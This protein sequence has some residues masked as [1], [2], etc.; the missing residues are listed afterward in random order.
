MTSVPER[1]SPPEQTFDVRGRTY[2]RTGLD[3]RAAEWRS[4]PY[5]LRVL[6]EG[7]VRCSRRRGGSPEAVNA[8]LQRRTGAPI[9][10]FP[11]RLL[12]QD[13]LGVPLLADL[14][15]L[16]DAVADAGGDPATVD[17]R[18]PVDLVIDHSLRVDAWAGAG[19]RA[20]NLRLEHE[21]NGERF[22]FLRWCERAFANLRVVPPG[23]GIM[24]QIN[25]ERLARV[26]WTED[27][28]KAPPLAYPD[29]LLGT[30][31]HTPMVNGIG[32][33]GWGVGGIEAEA[34]ML[35][36]PVTFAIPRVIGVELR[37]RLP[38]TSTPTDLALAVTE[39]LRRV[40]VAG[41]FVE[42]FGPGL[43]ALGA[44][45]RSTIANMAP[46]QGAT[47]S[48]FPVDR[49]TVEFLHATGRR[50]DQ[51][52]LV[53]AYAHEM[54]LWWEP[55][56]A[57]PDYDHVVP[58]DL[59]G[60]RPSIAGPRR[61]EDRIDLGEAAAAF[62]RHLA[63]ETGRGAP[64]S[65]SMN[66]VHE[67]RDGA[68]VIAAI[69]S[70]TNTSHPRGMA[71]AGLV[72]RNAARRGLRPKQWVKTS[73][74][75]G[76]RVVASM[77]ERSGLQ[78]DLDA[79]GFH[80]AGFGCATCNGM[81][82]PLDPSVSAAVAEGDLVAVAVVSSNRNFAGRIHPDVRAAYLASPALV[83]AYALAGSIAV[84]LTRQPLGVDPDGGPVHLRDLWPAP[85]EVDA[86][87]GEALLPAMFDADYADLFEGGERWRAL[88][89]PPQARFP[90]DPAS[91]YI[92]RPP[93]FDGLPVDPSPRRDIVGARPLVILGDSVTTD[94]ISPSGA[95]LAN[96]AAG[97]YLRER[98][99]AAADF[100]SYGTRR[101]NHEVMVR[102]TF[103]N[104]RLRNAIVPGTEGSVTRVFPEG[105]EATVF[106]AAQE[107]AR[108]GVP[109]VV[110]AG[111]DYGCGSSRDT[112][113]KG[114]A[115][116]GVRAV[117][118]RSFERIHRSNLV[119]TGILPLEL[120][121]GV[122]AGS[123]RLDGSETFD[124]R[125][126]AG[127]VAPGAAVECTVRR[128]DGASTKVLLRCRV[129]TDEEADR[130]RHGGILPAVW[131]EFAGSA[132]TAAEASCPSV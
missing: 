58:F 128:A 53:E 85:E 80:V 11:A 19:A 119:G 116:L 51:V 79:L 123:L 81:S 7:A 29:T 66:D 2:R 27:D 21:R 112:A 76:S 65:A 56:A 70:C 99:V 101:G 100:N 59:G 55:G 8:V 26:V 97:R 114:P 33:L 50:P 98:E 36:H 44:P 31:S 52:A 118:A 69:A 32:V 86:V 6:A 22:T 131:R 4:L 102:A 62:G 34:V 88:T 35:G 63:A 104:P 12:L 115:L 61:P 117:I 74:T 24:H 103:A 68:V 124:L 41:C 46:E 93:Y 5:S 15:A 25:V 127:G 75:P 39:L 89:L 13:L 122:D 73:L 23:K 38:H 78:D 125:L 91:T 96:S 110:V 28:G 105:R 60:V 54:G 120:P 108:R 111:R 82:G 37:G 40:G 107:Y 83:V 77:L 20:V 90:W 113:A 109:L 94:D 64:A 18:V 42:F 72:A 67:L 47:S 130:L 43:E 49:R 126:P 129:D 87:V 48:F 71:T 57:V 106:D 14:A 30:D 9:P 3:V 92:R 17:S 84:D 132:R 121:E 10:L 45:E 16:R 1:T 95:I